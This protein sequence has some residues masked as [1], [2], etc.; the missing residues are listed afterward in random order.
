MKKMINK[1]Q[2]TSELL[3]S[4]LHST[5]THWTV[6]L[7]NTALGERGIGLLLLLFSLTCII[8][9]PGFASLTGILVLVFA[10]HIV[11]GREEIWLPNSIKQKAIKAEHLKTVLS[12]TVPWMKRIEHLVRPRLALFS[13]KYVHK[14]TGIF[15]AIQALIII[16]PIPFGNLLPSIACTV[17]ALAIVERDGLLLLIGWFI[18]CFAVLYIYLL[19]NGYGWLILQGIENFMDWI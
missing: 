5:Q 3:Q 19:V 4:L 11:L 10:I 18:S 6:G 8:P 2:S 1:P 17:M 12:R 13:H 9:I 15:I 14:L 7:L 16:L